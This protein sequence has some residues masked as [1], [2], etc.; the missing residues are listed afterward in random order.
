MDKI[1]ELEQKPEDSDATPGPSGFGRSVTFNLTPT[2]FTILGSRSKAARPTKKQS[3]PSQRR[4]PAQQKG[5]KRLTRSKGQQSARRGGGPL[6]PPLP[7]ASAPVPKAQHRQGQAVG[8][9]GSRRSARIAAQ[10]AP[11]V[12]AGNTSQTRKRKANPSQAKDLGPS[13][14]KKRKPAPKKTAKSSAVSKK[15]TR[16]TRK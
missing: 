4:R 12:Q 9:V 11:P 1:I 3:S 14:A 6:S 15:G 13:P 8:Q 5:V 2:T 10:S 16:K 7:A